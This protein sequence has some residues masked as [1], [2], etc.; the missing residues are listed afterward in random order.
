[1]AAH[2]ASSDGRGMT[3][4]AANKKLVDE[5][6]QRLF[7]HGDLTAVDDLLSD[8]FVAHDLPFG[9]PSDA[10]GVRAAAATFRAAFSDW[11]SD[12]EQLIA[13]DDLVAE[14]FTAS[15]HHDG[16][17]LGIAPTGRR[18]ALPGTNVYRVRAGR[19]VEWWPQVDQ[20]GF[21]RALGV[22]PPAAM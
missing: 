8:D 10:S 21:L 20:L 5:F 2:A 3:D 6:V 18:C 13:E 19:I 22:I 14:R 1:M 4:T 9:L 15:G 12:V 17:L 16:E 11:H 7:T